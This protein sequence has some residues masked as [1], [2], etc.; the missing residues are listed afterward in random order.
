MQPLVREEKEQLVFH[1]PMR[2]STLAKARSVHRAA[3]IKTSSEIVRTR[4]EQLAVGSVSSNT[5]NLLKIVECIQITIAEESVEGSVKVIRT[6]FGNCQEVTT[7]RPS[8]LR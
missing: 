4:H 8:E 5:G 1:V 6:A 2:W 7:V 3:K